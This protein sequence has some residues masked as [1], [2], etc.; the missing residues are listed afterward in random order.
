MPFISF[1]KVRASWGQTGNDLIDPYQYLAS[2]TFND[3]M[4]LTN[5]GTT[6]NQALK[7]GVAP[8]Q[9]VTWETATQKNIGF[10]LQ[11]LNGDLAF[12][13]DY[14][15][16]KRSD[17]LWKRNASVPGTSGLVLPDENLGKVQNQGVDFNIDYRRNFKDFR[18]GI[19]LNG[20][21]AKN[22]ILFGMRHLVLQN[23]RSPQANLSIRDFIMKLSAYL[24]I[25]QL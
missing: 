5:N 23:G 13:I 14:F 16:N 18:L 17:I 2:Y 11:F 4:Y 20:V 1:A 15:Y 21:Y 12:T 25:R 7:E 3:L 24:K 22:K 10:D 8:N 19:N 9:N 6:M